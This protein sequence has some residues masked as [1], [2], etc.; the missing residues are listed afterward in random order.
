[1]PPRQKT[2]RGAPI[3]TS[4]DFAQTF[5]DSNARKLQELKQL[6]PE[7]YLYLFILYIRRVPCF[8]ADDIPRTSSEPQF[9]KGLETLLHHE[10]SHAA[11]LKASDDAK[12]SLSTAIEGLRKMNEEVV[13]LA[14]STVV[15][16][17]GEKWQD[18]FDQLA[19]VLE[20]GQ[21]FVAQYVLQ[22][23]GKKDARFTTMSL[24]ER[25]R[26]VQALELLGVDPH[27]VEL[28]GRC[29]RDVLADAVRSAV[30]MT[31]RLPLDQVKT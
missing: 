28:E 19:S 13:Q 21:D 5:R 14:N 6:H 23:M 15:P 2:S 22:V 11:V 8:H 3:D 31:K 25:E 30:K 10:E 7:T 4:D 29:D 1:M 27:E 16:H 20:A 17:V 24:K 18:D 26:Q 12:A 9:G